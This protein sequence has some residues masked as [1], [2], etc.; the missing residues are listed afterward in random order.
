M[1]LCRIMNV[2]SYPFARLNCL[3][4]HYEFAPPVTNVGGDFVRRVPDKWNINRKYVFLSGITR[5]TSCYCV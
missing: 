1:Q 3:I 4:S 5:R 2:N